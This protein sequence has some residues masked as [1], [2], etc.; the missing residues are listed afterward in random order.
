MVVE[1]MSRRA[2]LDDRWLNDKGGQRQ[3]REDLV[4]RSASALTPPS[5][6]GGWKGS[7]EPGGAFS[8]PRRGSCFFLASLAKVAPP[9]NSLV[10]LRGDAFYRVSDA[11]ILEQYR[12]PERSLRRRFWKEDTSGET[13]KLSCVCAICAMVIP[14]HRRDVVAW[15]P[16]L[17]R[18]HVKSNFVPRGRCA[19]PP[20][21]GKGCMSIKAPSGDLKPAMASCHD[22]EQLQLRRVLPDGLDH[23]VVGRPCDASATWPISGMMC[24]E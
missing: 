23:E 10:R 14:R 7:D 19:P 20:D 4:A 21:G 12:V 17:G 13:L 6:E 22:N 1:K 8:A 9:E 15:H 2:L 16:V 24:F 11:V 18:F 3:A 5:S